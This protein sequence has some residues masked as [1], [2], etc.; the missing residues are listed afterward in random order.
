MFQRRL[1]KERNVRKKKKKKGAIRCI[2]NY[3]TIESVSKHEASSLR[4]RKEDGQI[5]RERKKKGSHYSSN[6]IAPESSLSETSSR[7]FLFAYPLL[8]PILIIGPCAH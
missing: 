8:P 2:K 3:G 4:K 6:A 7:R 5:E 1:I